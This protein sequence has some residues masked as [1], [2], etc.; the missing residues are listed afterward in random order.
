MPETQNMRSVERLRSFL[1]GQIIYNNRMSTVDCVI[2]NISAYG[3]KIALN[4]GSTIPAEF[5]VYIP[6][7]GRFHHARMIWR[8]KDGMGVKFIDAENA[9]A[10]PPP[11]DNGA[12]D[13]DLPAKLRK[14]EMQNA[15]LKGRIRRLCKRLEDLGQD[16][17]V[18]A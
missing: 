2:K 18:D 14:L 17:N 9:S 5:D 15:E 4:E 8:D 10:A 16:P 1:R 3:A 6:Q 11:A 12:S 7:K 13:N